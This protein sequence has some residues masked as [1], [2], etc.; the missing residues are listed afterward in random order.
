MELYLILI[1]Y[2]RLFIFCMY[3][4]YVL[5]NLFVFKTSIFL[6]FIILELFIGIIIILQY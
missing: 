5:C 6:F 1:I 3:A 2:F 4:I